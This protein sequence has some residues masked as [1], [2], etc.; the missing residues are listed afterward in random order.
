MGSEKK[1]RKLFESASKF[2]FLLHSFITSHPTHFHIFTSQPTSL[3]IPWSSSSFSSLLLPLCPA[4]PPFFLSLL[5][6][7]PHTQLSSHQPQAHK[8]WAF[9]SQRP[10]QRSLATKRCASSCSVSMLLERLV[11]PLSIYHCHVFQHLMSTAGY[12]LRSP[13]AL[14]K[15]RPRISSMCHIATLYSSNPVHSTNPP[16]FCF[17]P[18]HTSQSLHFN[19][20]LFCPHLFTLFLIQL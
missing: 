2:C 13:E 9:L 7:F 20:F 8:K 14:L 1:A 5:C 3:S 17:T 6:P 15:F 11:C 18:T 4:S 12:F 10:L 19:L 16:F